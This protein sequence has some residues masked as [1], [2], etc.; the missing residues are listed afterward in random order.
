MKFISF[1]DLAWRNGI[2]TGYL[3]LHI[4][5]YSS[6]RGV[7]L[8]S[9]MWRNFSSVL[10]SWKHRLSS[11][12]FDTGCRKYSKLRNVLGLKELYWPH[13]RKD[14]AEKLVDANWNLIDWSGEKNGV[15]ERD[16]GRMYYL[17]ISCPLIH[18]YA[19]TMRDVTKFLSGIC[20]GWLDLHSGRLRCM[21]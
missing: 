19:R 2:S 12:F 9:F 5:H 1:W 20:L 3:L 7:I 8:G 10:W 13:L 6:V 15:S 11:K 17:P 4:W 14:D 18:M 21:T 16:W